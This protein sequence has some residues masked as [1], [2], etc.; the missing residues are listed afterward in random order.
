MDKA[1]LVASMRVAINQAQRQ[2][3][4]L[5]RMCRDKDI[6]TRAL[7]ADITQQHTLLYAMTYELEQTELESDDE[8]L[9]SGLLSE[10]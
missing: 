3:Q 1:K 5:E 10:E 8:K 6:R 4:Q 7:I 2:L 9:Y